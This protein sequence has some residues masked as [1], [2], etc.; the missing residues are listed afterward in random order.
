MEKDGRR[1]NANEA[2]AEFVK[3]ELKLVTPGG[4]PD[5]QAEIFIKAIKLGT[6]D[7][8]VKQAFA[9]ACSMK[10]IN[11]N[12]MLAV[13]S[14]VNAYEDM[15]AYTLKNTYRKW[16]AFHHSFAVDYP[17]ANMLTLIH[18]FVNRWKGII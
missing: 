6:D 12:N 9:R 14:N 17:K 4:D 5:Q 3:D 18:A 8:L 16:I 10:K 11:Y 13:L 7:P 15:I 2:M 1:L